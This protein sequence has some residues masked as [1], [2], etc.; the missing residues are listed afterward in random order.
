[1]TPATLIS[2]TAA[3]SEAAILSMRRIFFLQHAASRQEPYPSESVRRDRIAR[4]ID[5]VLAHQNELC[6]AIE[7][8]FGKRSATNTRLFDI[9]PPLNALKYAR[10]N[11]RRW[12]QPKR[13]RSN[14]PYNLIGAKS[15]VEYVPL[16][17]VGNLSPWNF[18]ITLA[19]SPMG[20]LLAAGNRVM[21]KPSE[22]TP[23]TSETLRRLI[24]RVFDISEISVVAGNSD[25]AVEFCK[26]K[27]DHILFTGSTQVGRLVAQSA[28]A[29]LVP[30]TLELGGKSPVVVSD[31][32]S[33]S[34]AA[35]RVAFAK[36]TNAGQIC[37]APD[38]VLVNKRNTDEFVKQLQAAANAM[39]PRGVTSDDYVN[40]IS[41]RHTA[42]LRSH[43]ND[44]VT[45]GN[46]VI[47]LFT[48]HNSADPRC[49]APQLVVMKKE[50]GSLMEEEIFGPLLPIIEVES[51]QDAIERVRARPR[52]LA[53]YYFG[54][55]GREIE[56]VTRDVACGGLVINDVMMHFVQDDL[57]FGG[58]GESGYGSYHGR[59]G[60]EHF[61][62][63]KSIFT[64]SRLIDLGPLLRPPFGSRIAR[65][66]KMELKR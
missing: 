45:H 23:A 3:Y 1:M 48:N 60:F 10:E 59:E 40:I 21:L 49:L 6:E 33:L 38:Y 12:M 20:G 56:Q 44:A 66:L 65:L 32:A 39:Y 53:L 19:F 34:K 46:R 25:V 41:E 26:L 62:H 24:E 16:G 43:L 50:T 18:P 63:A 28:A 42:R 58:I 14:F 52:P 15:E 51:T 36:L 22:L 7:Q 13:R 5:L 37:I 30:V 27:F 17:V 54:D 61:S 55:D 9:L 31:T 2:Q 29:N 11:L 57:P 47:H 64:Q 4:L 35:A 8:D